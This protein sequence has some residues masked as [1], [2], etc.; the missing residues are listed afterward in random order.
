MEI[1]QTSARRRETYRV[2]LK[3]SLL[4]ECALGI[5]AITNIPLLSSLEKN[6]AEWKTIKAAL[7]SDMQSQ[8]EVVQKRNTWKAL[9]QLLHQKNYTS[10]EEFIENVSQLSET[11]LKAACL[12]YLGQEFPFYIY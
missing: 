7:S 1:I 2:E 8:L 10:I 11:D 4:W 5:A 12:P 3:H 6:E 9:L